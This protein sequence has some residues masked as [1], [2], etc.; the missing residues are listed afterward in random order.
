[1]G[2]LGTIGGASKGIGEGI[3]HAANGAEKLL[4]RI[5]DMTSAPLATRRAKRLA[6]AAEEAARGAVAVAEAAGVELS[7]R[8]RRAI[9]FS[10][11]RDIQGFTN[12]ESTIDMARLPK[13]A[14]FGT[15]DDEWMSAF[16]NGARE[17]FSQW[18]RE[19]FARAVESKVADPSAMSIRA[20]HAISRMEREDIRRFEVVCGLRPE[21][22]GALLDPMIVTLD[23]S[24]LKVIGLSPEGIMSLCDVGVL[25][26]V[27]SR[28]RRVAVDDRMCSPNIDTTV[29]Q[30]S[31]WI[32]GRAGRFA[33]L[34]FNG[35]DVE[36]PVMTVYMKTAIKRETFRYVDYGSF[37][38]TDAGRSLSEIVQPKAGLRIADYIELSYTIEGKRE[39]ERLSDGAFS[40]RE[41]DRAVNNS[42]NRIIRK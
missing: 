7:G 3:E 41:F 29:Y 26:Q 40:E 27:S 20:L 18:K 34:R 35:V 10:A 14:D 37:Q 38:L 22:D 11:M 6:G 15:I 24:A 1:M 25:R 28:T 2:E 13:D 32:D 42:L 5:Q 19:T 23:P 17:A 39:S 21:V 31:H 33:T 36:I 4:A 8:D 16:V 9:A 30:R 12:I